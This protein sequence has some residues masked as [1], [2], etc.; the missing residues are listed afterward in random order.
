[1]ISMTI[2]IV[3]YFIFNDQLFLQIVDLHLR[4][5]IFCFV[6]RH[7]AMYPSDCEMLQPGTIHQIVR[8]YRLR[9]Y[10]GFLWSRNRLLISSDYFSN[11][12]KGGIQDYNAI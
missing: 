11:V 8:G 1:M 4:L 9:K 2:Q 12:H 5:C 3:V 10:Y 6:L 7:D